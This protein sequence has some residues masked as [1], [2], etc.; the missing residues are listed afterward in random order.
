MDF[1]I[2]SSV[3]V[4]G[5]AGNLGR[6]LVSALLQAPW[7]RRVVGLDL[8]AVPE[9]SA[10]DRL[11]FVTGDLTDPAGSWVEALVGLDAV[12]HL[13]AE[14]PDV[15]ATWLQAARSF[16]M[17]ANLGLAAARHGVRRFV[18]ASS[19]HVM[20]GY[21]DAP[22]ADRLR[23]SGLTATLPPAPGTRWHDG[24]R[25]QDS[26]AYATAKLMGERFCA[27]MAAGSGGSLTS[28]AL[29]IGWAQPGDNRP[30]TISH[31]GSVIGGLPEADTPEARRDLRWFRGMWLSNPDLAALALAAVSADPSA[32]PQPGIVVNGV[33]NNRD[34]DWDLASGA[35]LIGYRPGSDLF[36]ELNL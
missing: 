32:W 14:N 4:T 8:A 34:T 13:A 20:G 2:P 22:L 17:T 7:C 27:A 35:R 31:A 19:N 15:D 9:S 16:D 23:P 3:L 12:V 29:R 11:S 30:D 10:D 1:A 18:F 36:A 28:V 33:S 26:T 5:A 6:K 25:Q 21:K 24:T